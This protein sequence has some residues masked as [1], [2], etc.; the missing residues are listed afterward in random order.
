MTRDHFVINRPPGIRQPVSK[1]VKHVP[2]HRGAPPRH[3]LVAGASQGAAQ[4]RDPVLGRRRRHRCDG[5]RRTA[6]QPGRH[7]Q[8]PAGDLRRDAAPGRR[9]R[10]LARRRHPQRRRS[11]A[12]RGRARRPG[13]RRCRARPTGATRPT[14]S[15]RRLWP[16]TAYAPSPAQQDLSDADPRDDRP[17]PAGGVRVLA[18][19]VHLPRLALHPRVQLE[20]LRRQPH[21][22]PPTASRRRC[23]A[24]RWPSVGP[25]WE[26][27]PVTQ[28]RWGLGYIQDRYGTPCGAWSHSQGHGW[29]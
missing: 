2:K 1:H 23:P 11:G 18:R 20:R 22:R 10:G 29:Y 27:N 14:R 17:G 19:P 28:I 15:R 6:D 5:R 12:A 13:A 24:R 3:A 4:H 26:T 25:D 16:P 21:P 8:C 9:L 7:D